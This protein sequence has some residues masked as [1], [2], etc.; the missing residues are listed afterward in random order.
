MD[1]QGHR[2]HVYL[3]KADS[4]AIPF[5][6]GFDLDDGRPVHVRRPMREPCSAL[7]IKFRN[8][9][10]HTLWKIALC[11]DA[12][13]RNTPKIED[14]FD[15]QGLRDIILQAGDMHLI[16]DPAADDIIAEGS[17]QRTVNTISDAIAQSNFKLAV[18]PTFEEIGEIIQKFNS[19][20]AK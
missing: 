11:L 8:L 9:L 15:R 12:G 1:W 14:S 20:T 13:Y 4:H 3:H 5:L 2:W 19:K 16:C 17:S 18:S 10:Q 6:H 7:T